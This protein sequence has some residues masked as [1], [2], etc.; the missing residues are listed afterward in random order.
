M[1][2]HTYDTDS[3]LYICMYVH[4]DMYDAWYI[5]MTSSNVG[6]YVYIYTYIHLYID[7]QKYTHVYVYIYICIYLP[8]LG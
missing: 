4:V 7:I 3:V 8:A 6:A 5:C 1:S 2:I